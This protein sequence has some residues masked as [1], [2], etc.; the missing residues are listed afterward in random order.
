MKSASPTTSKTLLDALKSNPESSRWIEFDGKYRPWMAKQLRVNYPK[1]ASRH[2]DII[3]SVFVRVFKA[4]PS[5]KFID[6]EVGHFR[7]YLKCIT[8][9]VVCDLISKESR[10]EAFEDDDQAERL[11]F[12]HEQEFCETES[13][14]ERKKWMSHV[15]YIAFN[16]VL[17]DEGLD[18]RTREV[19]YRLVIKHQKP[20]A[21]LSALGGS[22]TANAIYQMKS[23][24]MTKVA[25]NT[26]SLWAV[27]VTGKPVEVDYELRQLWAS[28]ARQKGNAR[29]T[30]ELRSIAID[31]SGELQ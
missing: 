6:G 7:S 29:I 3:Q 12:K 13:E 4:L 16:Q 5:Y 15:L 21:I 14:K 17:G 23:R 2:E 9:N 27:L 28:L 10:Y 22:L 30:R 26:R 20:D 1:M 19:A 31:L 11:R 18:A 25:K 8:R 24:V